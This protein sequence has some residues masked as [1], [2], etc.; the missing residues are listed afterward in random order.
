MRPRNQNVHRT[1][2]VLFDLVGLCLA[3]K[4][5][6]GLRIFI[7]PIMSLPLR[8]WDADLW[9]PRLDL[10]LLL[11]V[12]VAFWLKIYSVPRRLTWHKCVLR[13]AEAAVVVSCITIVTVFFSR[14]FGAGTSRSFVVIFAP[15]SFVAFVL[16]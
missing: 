8:A 12:P 16:A 13:G 2:Q 3:W 7:N 5:T 4:L 1:F 11:W 10:I 9:A 15:T 14:G 6:I